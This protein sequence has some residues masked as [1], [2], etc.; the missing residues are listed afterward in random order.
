MKL[1]A[2]FRNLRIQFKIKS[3]SSSNRQEIDWEEEAEMQTSP[4]QKD[5]LLLGSAV[6]GSRHSEK[7][8]ESRLCSEDNKENNGSVTGQSCKGSPKMVSPKDTRKNRIKC[9]EVLHTDNR[10]KKLGAIDNLSP[11]SL[12]STASARGRKGNDSMKYSSIAHTTFARVPSAKTISDRMIFTP[13]SASSS[14]YKS[15]SPATQQIIKEVDSAYMSS[16]I[17]TSYL[18]S[19]EGK[20]T[21]NS[22]KQ[23]LE[24]YAKN[25]RSSTNPKQLHEKEKEALE[26]K[27]SY[28]SSS[29]G[30]SRSL[31]TAASGVSALAVKREKQQRQARI[32]DVQSKGGVNGR[33][34]LDKRTARLRYGD[35]FQADIAGFRATNSHLNNGS[36][37]IDK[38]SNEIQ[39]RHCNGICV[40]VRKRPLFDYEFDRGD[41][42]VVSI[43]NTTHSDF[44]ECIVHN[45]HMHPDMKQML[46]KITRFPVTAAFDERCSDDSI[47]KHVAGPLVKNAAEGGISTI[48]MYGQTG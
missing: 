33:Q 28:Q 26:R 19:K 47:Y 31:V 23:V 7:L 3:F 1:S 44:D 43:D 4:T 42:D 27:A 16:P 17:P 39:D 13:S 29:D 48:L 46:I 6:L 38:V 45:C 18:R 10:H 36:N 14:E 11:T 37:H 32:Q 34:N 25:K 41:Y 22:S 5:D 15:L 40:F 12:S 9:S 24:A 20:R 35:A 8:V 30:R 21:P 2:K